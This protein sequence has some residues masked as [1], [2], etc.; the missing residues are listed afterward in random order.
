[1][2]RR[3]PLLAAAALL[4]AAGAHAQVST[5]T[6][7][8]LGYPVPV[9]VDTAEA[10]DG[11][12]TYDGLL[13]KGTEI[14]LAH[15]HVQR[16]QLGATIEGRPIFGYTISA[17]D[18]TV[19]GL[20]RQGGLLVAGTLHAREW[21]SPEIVTQYLEHL[22]EGYGTDAVT[23]WLVDQTRIV[24]LPVINVD[25]FLQTQRWPT[26]QYQSS[27]GRMRRKN[28]RGVDHDL[29]TFSDNLLGVDLN[30]N[31][32]VGWSGGF[33]SSQTYGGTAPFSEPE[34]N[35]LLAAMTLF[36]DN[37]QLRCY[38]DV[39]G[40]IPALYVVYHNQPRIDGA[41]QGLLNRK[42][43]TYTAR[44]GVPNS[45]PGISVF[46]NG[47]I[48]ATDEY[49]GYTF[50]VP[51]FTV[52]YPTPNYRTTGFGGATFLLPDAQVHEVVDENIFAMQLGAMFAAGP[53]ILETATFWRD[54]NGDG[55]M[56]ESEI[57]HKSR[58]VADG[59][60]R[61][62]VDLV[63]DG[64]TPLG[65][66][67]RVVLQFDRPMRRFEGRGGGQPANWPGQNWPLQPTVSLAVPTEGGTATIAATASGI[68]WLR[69][70]T[71]SPGARR[72]EGDTW[73]GVVDLSG[74]GEI[75]LG[76]DAVLSV[77]VQDL[78]GFRL[79]A[80]PATHADWLPSIPGRPAGWYSYESESGADTGLGG[81]DRNH[82]VRFAAPPDGPGTN[83]LF[84]G[85]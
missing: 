85:P 68:G 73:S 14:W 76:Q 27:D 71:A 77:D 38:Y 33:P 52:E 84:F 53:P 66:E 23:T 72:Y 35:A 59:D 39:H 21:G 54:A 18:T 26:Q 13:T 2:M 45:Y 69:S 37:E 4:L 41:T 32:S 61:V 43:A 10:F 25:G 64:E 29:F 78:Y 11:F 58:W 56:Q 3:M 49:F 34:S 46:P 65:G 55:Q 8:G 67:L 7:A 12:R 19:D 57:V 30:R 22:A 1:M 16:T 60:G 74:A 17:G 50:E 81:I 28:M 62:R 15:D 9:P 44:N 82:A 51:S 80:D 5:Y 47:T 79:D 40:A 83:W 63:G 20:P 42:R 6:Q 24:L 70:S 48:G 31:M 36:E 75:L